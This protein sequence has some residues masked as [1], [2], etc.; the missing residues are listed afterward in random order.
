M[1]HLF[2]YILVLTFCLSVQF[3]QAKVW[4]NEFMQSN[5]D[6]VRDDL[7]EFPD[8]W[9]ELYN[10]SDEA[11][12]IYNWYISDNKNYQ[13][14]WRITKSTIIPAQSYLLIYC[15]TS[16]KG[17][18][19]SFRIDSG[20]G[21]DIYVFDTSG[22]E[23][24]KVTGIPKQ[25]APN[26]ARGRTTDGSNTWAYF[27]KATP[28]AKNQGE[29]AEVLFPDPVFSES[30]KVSKTALRISLSLPDNIKKGI[31]T[32]QIYYTTDGSEPSEKSKRY[33]EALNITKTTVVRA[34]IIAS[35]G[36][37]N[38]SLAQTYIIEN[39]DFT[40]PVIS[41][42]LD[43]AF[44]WDD[45]FG[46]YTDGNGKYGIAGN[47]TEQKVNWNNDWRRPMN[48]EYFP[49]QNASAAL[50]QLGEMRIAG[51]CSRNNPQKPFI[52]Y[53]NKRFGEKKRYDYPFFAEKPNQE[54]KSFMIRNSG[55]DFWYTQFRDAA[56]QLFMGGKV[57]LDYQA[58]QPA[59]LFI[60]GRY[61]G[62]QNLRERSDEDF[63]L[64][65]YATEDIDMIENW[66]GELK[67]GDNAAWN[68]LMYELR[69]PLAERDMQWISDQIDINEYINYMILEIYAANTDF[70][71]NNMVMWRK[72]EDSG[73][74]R[75]IIKDLDHTLGIWDKVL[76]DFD[77]ISYN[78]E[79]NDESRKLF[80]AL[81]TMDSFQK[82]FYS[83]FAVYLGDIL[84]YHSTSQVIDS[85][86]Q[87]IEPEMQYH[88]ERWMPEMWW[89][90]MKSWY[91]EINKM[92]DWCLERNEYMYTHLKDYFELGDMTKLRIE[93]DSEDFSDHLNI[94]FNGIKLQKP[95]FDGSYFQK[96]SIELQLE[97]ENPAFWAWEVT[98][99]VDENTTTTTYFQ[100]EGL[101][102]L[103]PEKCT[104]LKIKI[105]RNPTGI[106]LLEASKIIIS[107]KENQIRITGLESSSQIS[108]F[109]LNGRLI[110]GLKTGADSVTIPIRN[111]GAYILK[112]VSNDFTTT[113][114]V[115][116]Y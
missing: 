97:T 72:K 25:P 80:N 95:E 87:L 111:K 20:K 74:W 16:G 64:A 38:R 4:I 42:S 21:G 89:R 46:I 29:T 98:A 73:Q 92:S 112:I 43:P 33:S 65:N 105:V 82:E 26:I 45:E 28:N 104:N 52:I 83:R 99:T 110:S 115:V 70:P 14:G 5:I 23:I 50:N 61:W 44:L 27:V 90:D 79:S 91:D 56:C 68:M 93:T 86:K 47:C 13:K 102:Y 9:L 69:K 62:I 15:D 2:H 77:A 37:T 76:P 10:D 88:L 31:A 113:R 96:E 108:V 41:L 106:L 55:N 81:L 57:D 107:G 11:V 30:G 67:A 6:L 85:I 12:D 114:K 17:I 116:V 7:Q 35:G 32:S 94:L 109:D 51:G 24:D 78:T 66:W 39:R 75:F 100:P 48:F 18:H 59:S 19:T 54:I 22:D 103:I 34:K 8:S 3:L 58:Y 1:K 71:G 63:V 60:N 40:L 49:F 84:H 53:G 36:L 101:S